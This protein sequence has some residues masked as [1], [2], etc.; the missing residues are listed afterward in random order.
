MSTLL[1]SSVISLHSVVFFL[2]FLAETQAVTYL[3]KHESMTFSTT[4]AMIDPR[5]CPRCQTPLAADAPAGLCPAC[6]FQEGLRTDSAA[7]EQA[8]ESG[9]RARFVPP[10]PAE[11]AELFP[12]LEILELIG[13]GG[14]GAVYKARQRTLERLVA[15]KILPPAL[16]EAPSFS[17]RFSR[18]ARTMARLCHPHIVWLLE[19]GE[20]QRM[21]YLVMEYV[22]GTNLRQAMRGARLQPREALAIVPQICEALAYAHDAGVIHRD[23]KPENILLDRKGSVKIA[24]FGLAKLVSPGTPGSSITGS[25]QALG[26]PHY[27]APEQLEHPQRVDKRADIYALGVV[28]YEM[29]TGELP[30]GR[31]APPSSKAAVDVRLDEVIHKALEKEPERRYQS[32]VE[33]QSD[34]AEI[35]SE[36]PTPAGRPAR[37]RVT[38][39]RLWG[40]WRSDWAGDAWQIAK[41]ALLCVYVFCMLAFF[42]VEGNEGIDRT[43]GTF[44]KHL[45][46]APRA[47]LTMYYF[48]STGLKADLRFDSQGWCSLVAGLGAYYGYW[49][50][51]KT[52]AGGKQR[53][54]LP[55]PHVVL[56][57]AVAVVSIGSGLNRHLHELVANLWL[58]QVSW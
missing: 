53:F 39:A 45:V 38:F 32:A 19:F 54:R 3:K 6:L 52:E 15:L 31:F 34:V 29:L 47:W 18:E 22:E 7:S 21:P 26:T 20:C 16:A 55:W 49:R 4:T 13:Y 33:V 57:L 25:Q 40:D 50:I 46:G 5:V 14:M 24:D 17:E 37:T 48:Q 41:L 8:S 12:Q 10:T 42:S 30:L 28:F 56:W 2:A 1:L 43:G 27:M 11:L 36:A 44:Y 58:F 35:S 51:R 23:I 9:S